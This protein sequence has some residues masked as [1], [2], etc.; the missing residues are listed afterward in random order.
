MTTNGNGI[1][2]INKL[3]FG[4]YLVQETGVSNAVT[5]E[6]V[7]GK[8]VEEKV[9]FSEKQYPYVVSVPAW[10][11][12]DN[13]ENWYVDIDARAKNATE[14][15]NIDKSI[16]RDA[17]TV[18]KADE[19][20]HKNDVTH[21]GDVVEFT[22][23]ADVPV[24]EDPINRNDKIESYE[25]HDNISAGLTVNGTMASG[26]ID[27]IDNDVNG[28]IYVV[29]GSG[30]EY[31]LT[32][33]DK[34]TEGDYYIT[35]YVDDDPKEE[36]LYQVGYT[37][38]IKF[39]EN[40]LAKLTGY[41]KNQED[42]ANGKYI[43][44]NYSATV[45][46]NAVVGSAGNPNKVQLQYKAAGSSE[47][48]TSWHEVTEF[49][50]TMDAKK[51]FDGSDATKD[52][53]G[54]V[55]FE[56]YLDKEGKRPVLLDE[57]SDSEADKGKYTYHGEGTDE[58]TE[59]VLTDTGTFSIKGVPVTN[60]NS[61]EPVTLYLKETATAP[62]Y[63]KLTRLIPITLVPTKVNDEYDGSLADTSTVND[64]AATLVADS[65]DKNSGIS[66]TVNNTS[67]FQLPSTGGMGIWMFVI[68]GMAVIGCG[69]LYYRRN[70]SAE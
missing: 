18:N 21:I 36:P 42:L 58:A 62:D 46:A 19:G 12:K 48:S 41:A 2:T 47:I 22:L 56:L 17:N 7:D 64:K 14:T 24:L 1:G 65:T 25:I 67:G 28:N 16:Q 8:T 39:T 43:K 4:I 27:E 3:P 10:T 60:E 26:W 59:I 45:N 20:K 29:D 54:A 38:T 57:V 61:K 34:K 9:Y 55:K 66:F 50:F 15:V 13:D 69:L 23:L 49:I 52:Q 68:G 31:N 33:E 32:T 11:K 51:T 37:F 44:V 5:V 35:D 53:A 6:T 70:K 30:V 63:N 40:G